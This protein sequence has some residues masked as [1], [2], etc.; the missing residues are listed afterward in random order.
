MRNDDEWLKHTMVAWNDGE[1]E[2]YYADVYL[3]GELQ[4]YT[5]KECSY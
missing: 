3:E 1:P 4:E 2:I 5:P